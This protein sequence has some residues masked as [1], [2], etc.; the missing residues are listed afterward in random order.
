ML[1]PD[2]QE[3]VRA[4]WEKAREF[5]DNDVL[6]REANAREKLES[7]GMTFVEVDKDLWKEHVLGYYRDSEKMSGDWDMDLYER[8]MEAAQ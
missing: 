8:V 7:E 3:K 2:L 1:G 5:C 6:E 4:A